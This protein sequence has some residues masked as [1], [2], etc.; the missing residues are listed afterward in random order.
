VKANDVNQTIVTLNQVAPI[1]VT[2]SL[3][4]RSLPQIR[5][6]VAAGTAAVTVVDRNTGL[7][8]DDGRLTFIDNTVDATTGTITLKAEFANE[9]HALWPGQFVQARLAVATDRGVVVVPSAA[10]QVG[11]NSAQVYVVKA[12][13]TVELRPV[14][15]ARTIGDATVLTSGV[16]RGETVVT[17]GQ[18]RLVPGAKVEAKALGGNAATTTAQVTP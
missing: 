10:V 11:Q 18:L 12:D 9:D 13:Q 5:T 7:S 2:F 14:Q 15:V 4:E 1:N 6:A 3:A 17:D 16:R 8:R